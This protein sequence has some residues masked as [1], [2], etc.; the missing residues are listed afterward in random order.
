MRDVAIEE[1][2]GR[3]PHYTRRMKEALSIT[4]DGVAEIFKGF[5][6]DV[7]APPEFM[8]FRYGVTDH[9]TGEFWLDHC[10]ALMDVE[11]MGE[12]ITK[13][14]C[15]DIEDPTF[16]HR[17]GHNPRAGGADPPPPRDPEGRTPHC[18]WKVWIDPEAEPVPLPEPAVSR[19]PVGSSTSGSRPAP[20][21]TTGQGERDDYRG[22]LLTD[23]VFSGS[24][25][26][27]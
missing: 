27:R 9:G 25:R 10:G 23:L 17:P 15:H 11:P 20:R 6:L 5:Q 8:D 13:T 26:R 2:A 1:W 7:G 22:P 21:D 18:H 24:P 19:R 14:M 16:G 3:Q 12:R 4:G